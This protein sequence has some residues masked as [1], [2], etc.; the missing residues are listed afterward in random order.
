MRRFLP[1]PDVLEFRPV[2]DGM[3]VHPFSPTRKLSTN[4]VEEV[5][6]RTVAALD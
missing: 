2:F 4:G 1:L 5:S 3:T 6:E